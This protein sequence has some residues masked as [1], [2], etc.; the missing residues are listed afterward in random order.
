[1]ILYFKSFMGMVLPYRFPLDARKTNFREPKSV[2][3]V[4]VDI[5]GE[6]SVTKKLQPIGFVL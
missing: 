4:K 5:A 3:R 2:Q 1:M 6:R